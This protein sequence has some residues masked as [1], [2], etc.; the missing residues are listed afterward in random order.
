MTTV[1]ERPKRLVA[2]LS[3]AQIRSRVRV[4]FHLDIP[5]VGRVEWQRVLRGVSG[6]RLLC[7]GR[8]AEQAFVAKLFFHPFRA[9]KHWQ[10][11]HAGHTLFLS[12]DI[13]TPPIRYAGYLENEDLYAI[14]FDFISG[15]LSGDWRAH[16]PGTVDRYLEQIIACLAEHHSKGLLQQDVNPG[17]FLLH[18]ESVLSLDGDHVRLFPGPI[19]KKPALQ[20]LALFF[21]NFKTFSRE[22]LCRYYAL[23]AGLRLWPVTEQD[24]GYVVRHVH[25]KQARKRLKILFRKGRRR[26]R[27]HNL[28]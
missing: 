17:N 20:N 25:R 24:Q 19:Q 8:G 1:P 9:K 15:P 27:R 13:A 3:R 11:S 23:Y 18:K 5:G 21:S 4:C 6:K 7:Y 22:D 12:R 14:V 28:L 10:R 16:S 2:N 26:K